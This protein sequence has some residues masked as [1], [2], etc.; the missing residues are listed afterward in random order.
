M[1]KS[2]VVI[3]ATVCLEGHKPLE[4]MSCPIKVVSK[5]E[6]IRRK[7]KEANQDPELEGSKKRARSEDVLARLRS[8]EGTLEQ[9]LETMRALVRHQNVQVD[10]SL[11]S[12]DETASVPVSHEWMTDDEE[13]SFISAE[14]MSDTSALNSESE[15]VLKRPF[16]VDAF[17]SLLHSFDSV[18]HRTANS[19][20][21]GEVTSL[22]LAH[23]PLDRLKASFVFMGLP[24][25]P[26]DAEDYH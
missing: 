21:H 23:I 26:V 11:L 20:L 12:D 6:Q 8:V 17:E 19:D 14:T 2:C 5:P 1:A 18:S 13:P 7:R 16:L 10:D 24:T 4:A 15:P 25:A 9:G 22:D 3:K